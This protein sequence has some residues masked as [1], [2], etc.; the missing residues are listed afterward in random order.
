[1]YGLGAD[2][3]ECTAA[4]GGFCYSVGGSNLGG[5]LC[6]SKTFP[7]V[8]R[9]DSA[10]TCKVNADNNDWLPLILL[11]LLGFVVVRAVSK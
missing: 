9:T 5:K 10:G 1:M 2:G 11:G 6:L 4:D 3:E 8:G 7:F